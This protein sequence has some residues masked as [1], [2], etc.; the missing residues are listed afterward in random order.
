M[1]LPVVRRDLAPERPMGW[2]EYVCL[3]DDVHGEYIDGCLV[4]TPPSR[5]HQNAARRLARLLEQHLLTG[6]D[7]VT[8][9]GWKPGADEY[10]PDVMVHPRTDEQ[11][12]FTGTPLLCVEVLSTNR[13][14]D[15]VR[16]ASKYARAG[17]PQYWVLDPLEPS[18]RMYALEDGAYR[19][20]GVVT[21][22]GDTPGWPGLVVDLDV[23][24]GD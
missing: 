13:G 18:L 10:G 4:G 9:W 3:G 24:L 11:V 23:L 14:D 7:V 20:V 6:H 15:L 2:D 5:Q 22:R 19:Q 8:A 12:R 1:T 17:L 16:K 21:G